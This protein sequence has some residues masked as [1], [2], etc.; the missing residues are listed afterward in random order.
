MGLIANPSVL[1]I[2]IWTLIVTLYSAKLLTIYDSLKFETFLL[3]SLNI[4]VALALLLFSYTRERVPKYT[5]TRAVEEL[6]SFLIPKLGNVRIYINYSLSLYV[7]ISVL[8]IYY[9]QGLPLLWVLGGSSLSYVDF[10]IPTF[11]G[12]AN[13]IVFF[14]ASFL[15]LLTV[16]KVKDYKVLLFL[17]FLYQVL[18]LSRGTIVVMSVQMLAVIFFTTRFNF[19][20]SFFLV[21]FLVIFVVGFGMLG[22]IRQGG[23][24]PYYGFVTEE[25][26]ELFRSIPSGFLW[27][28]IYF[29]SGLNNLNFNIGTIEHNYLPVYTFAKLIP[30]IVYNITGI[31]KSVDAIV[32]VNAGL[33]VSTVYSAFYSDFGVSAFLLVMIVQVVASINYSQAKAGNVFALLK[34]IVA[35]QAIFLSF[36]IDTFFYLPFLFQYVIIYFLKTF[37]RVKAA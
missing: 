22:D 2:T 27:F 5:K 12:L 6:K 19:L 24:N 1:F 4:A 10:G 28:Y 9:S 35:Y 33:N 29:T 13:S 26:L 23:A 18:I 15:T 11:H 34:Y 16:L 31:E 8:D 3:I 37:L 32:F 20:K 7:L 30:S 17:L 14:L 25:Y 36:F 21:A